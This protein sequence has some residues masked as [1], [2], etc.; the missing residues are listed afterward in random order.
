ME[1]LLVS[2]WFVVGGSVEYLSVRRGSVVG[3]QWAGGA[4]VGGSVVGASVRRWR[5]CWWFGGGLSVVGD[6]SLIGGFVTRR[7]VI[8]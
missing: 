4:L 2:Q 8:R 3:D 7:K 5:T 6:L 1:D